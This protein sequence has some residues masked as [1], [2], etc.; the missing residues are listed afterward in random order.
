MV[1][2]LPLE[3][4]RQIMG[5]HPWHFWGLAGSDLAKLSSKCNSLVYQYAWQNTDAGSRSDIVAAIENAEAMMAREMG[6]YPAPHWGE[7]VVQYPKYYD[8]SL[9]RTVMAD[10]E[11][12]WLQV[13]LKE[14]RVQ[15]MGVPVWTLLGSQAVTLSDSD[16]DGLSDVFT[17]AAVATTETNS[18]NIAVYFS[19]GD[20]LDTTL[21]NWEIAPVRKTI[22]G[23]N[24]V[25]V[26]RAWQIV[27]PVLY[28][29]QSPAGLDPLVVANYATTVDVYVR[30]NNPDGITN[31]DCQAEL[32]WE[33]LPYPSWA[34][35]CGCSSGATTPATDPAAEA[36]AVARAG[37][38]D[39]DTGIV[40]FGRAVYNAA[41]GIWEAVNWGI[42][43]PPDRVRVRYLAGNALANGQMELKYQAAVARLAAAELGRPICACESANRE[44]YR[45][46]FD[47]SR[48]SGAADESYAYM[49][50]EQ[51]NN[52][53]GMR[54]GHVYAWKFVQDYRKFVGFS[55]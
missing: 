25:I 14:G 7:E 16:G 23:G 27:K 12:H 5:Y 41:T 4:W 48:S 54:R 9:W 18:D 28:E 8:R 51:L 19:A 10:A 2:L 31:D 50:P 22:A 38:R 55:M 1:N 42:C 6:Y 34:T 40:Y 35:C 46:Q 15:Q 47:L 39:G 53:F 13:R 26:G 11:G 33:T 3:K 37:I 21:E 30:K 45:W 52:P 36:Y 17:T 49:S 32:I 43:R 24:V 29:G 20:R 44:V